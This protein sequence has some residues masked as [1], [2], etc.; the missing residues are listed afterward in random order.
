MIIA[1]GAHE[2]E[3][4]NARST[5][6]HAMP[7]AEIKVERL[8]LPTPTRGGD[9]PFSGEMAVPGALRGTFDIGRVNGIACYNAPPLGER[10]VEG[11]SDAVCKSLRGIRLQSVRVKAL[12]SVLSAQIGG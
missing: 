5:Q 2:R 11:R 3:I 9:T 10:R 6:M 12:R 7:L 8:P 4:G 1:D